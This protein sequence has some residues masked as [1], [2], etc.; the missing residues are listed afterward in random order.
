MVIL[1]Q[2]TCYIRLFNLPGLFET[3]ELGGGFSIPEDAWT[4]C[5][6]NYKSLQYKTVKF[7]DYIASNFRF[8]P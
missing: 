6:F 4:I 8:S 7:L 3:A 5:F 1:S 2:H